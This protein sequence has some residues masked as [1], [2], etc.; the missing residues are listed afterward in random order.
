MGRSPLVRLGVLAAFVAAA[1]ATQRTP[2]P[3]DAGP[4]TVSAAERAA[5][6]TYGTTIGTFDRQL[7]EQ[8]VASADPRARALIER[9]DGIITF[10][11]GQSPGAAGVTRGDGERFEI[12]LDLGT[13]QRELGVRGVNRVVLHEIGHVIDFALVPAE[14]GARLDAAVPAGAPCPPGT[15]IGACA[16]EAERFAETFAKWAMNDIGV[17]LFI[18]YA[19]PPP[20][21]FES[22]AAPLVAELST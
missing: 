18:G 21:S 9:V 6:F 11:I 15:P 4:P 16:P 17:D 2:A 10:E 20:A 14:L 3:R 7:I 13:T 8:A 5:G 22:W 19:V 12:T 1:L